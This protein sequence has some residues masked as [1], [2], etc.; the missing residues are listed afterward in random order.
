MTGN[1]SLLWIVNYRGEHELVSYDVTRDKAGLDLTVTIVDNSGKL[2]AAVLMRS[3]LRRH[4]ETL[5]CHSPS[6]P[7]TLNYRPMPGP[8]LIPNLDKAPKRVHRLRLG[9]RGAQMTLLSPCRSVHRT[10]V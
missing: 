3:Q 4:V 6:F 1:R 7:F 9:P 2:W 10:S 5:T 8:N